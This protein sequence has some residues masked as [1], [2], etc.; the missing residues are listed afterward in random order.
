MALYEDDIK[1]LLAYSSISHMGY[2]LLGIASVS[3]IGLAGVSFHYASHAF[4]KAVLFMTA[5]LLMMQFN[6]NRRIS[7]MGGLA[8]K[9]PVV[10]FFFASGFLGLAGLPPFAGFNS[11]LLIFTG[12]FGTNDW[13]TL[14]FVIGATLSSFLTLAYGAIVFKRSMLGEPKMGPAAP[15]DPLMIVSIAFLIVLSMIFFL[16]PSIVLL[17]MGG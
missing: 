7:M 9:V 16:M 5:G 6:G 17:P 3:W 8:S 1:R 13:L 4:L 12:S 15:V 11:K 2:M 10:A 14:A